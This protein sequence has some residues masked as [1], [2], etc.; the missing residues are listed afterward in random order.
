[1]LFVRKYEYSCFYLCVQ[2]LLAQLMDLNV[3]HLF[4]AQ[5]FQFETLGVCLYLSSVFMNLFNSCMPKDA[6][7]GLN[8]AKFFCCMMIVLYFDL[9]ILLESL[10]LVH[11][12][13]LFYDF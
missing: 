7:F 2:Q 8:P 4:S 13:L 10:N 6:D 12:I 3:E 5:G 1:M 11:G 9:P